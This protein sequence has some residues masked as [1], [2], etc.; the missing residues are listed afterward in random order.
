MAFLFSGNQC[1]LFNLLLLLLLL[2][3]TSAIAALDNSTDL[4]SLLA[5]KA[6]TS[7]GDASDINIAANWTTDTPFCTWV[8]V[9]CSRRRSRVVSL[10]L[11]SFSL[12]CTIS[13][14]LS[15]LSF[16]SSL[17]LSNNSLSGAIPDTL[18]RLPR[19]ATLH[20][21]HNLLTG[22][23][24]RSIFNMSSLVSTD[25]SSNNLSSY[26]PTLLSSHV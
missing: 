24:P 9:G 5:F 19:L 15:N 26:L 20:L 12:Q 11:S 4:S 6:S 17:D 22:P 23:I 25:M 21:G 3:A 18:G 10:N 14:Q 8:G 16:L 13:P 7:G 1:L 2:H